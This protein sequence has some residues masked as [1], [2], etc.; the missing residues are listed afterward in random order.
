MFDNLHTNF[1]LDNITCNFDD[2][3][4][5][6]L[7]HRSIDFEFDD[8]CHRKMHFIN[9]FENQMLLLNEEVQDDKILIHRVE[10]CENTQ[11]QQKASI[12]S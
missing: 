3:G 7:F 2:F 8:I 10:L 5:A 4:D 12:V 11:C 9:H 6:V 1:N